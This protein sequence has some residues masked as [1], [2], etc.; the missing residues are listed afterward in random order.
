MTE[1][2][3][4]TVQLQEENICVF[5]CILKATSSRLAGFPTQQAAWALAVA[6]SETSPTD[7][8]CSVPEPL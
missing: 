5:N 6:R 2:S 8:C 4:A 7:D 3:T 1:D